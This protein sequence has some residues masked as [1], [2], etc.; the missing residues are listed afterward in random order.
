[1]LY[2]PQT[3][4]D[5]MSYCGPRW[6]T[7]YHYNRLMKITAPA[8]PASL[9]HVETAEEAAGLAYVHLSGEQP[10]L[11]V[12]GQMIEDDALTLRPFWINLLAPGQYD[13][14]GDGPYAIELLDGAGQ[15]LFVRRFDPFSGPQGGDH[16]AGAFHEILP[17]PAGVRRIVIRHGDLILAQVPVSAHAPTAR[18]LTPHADELWA[19]AGPFSVTWEMA[20]ADGDPL[21]TQVLYT[22]DGGETWLPVAVNLSGNAALLDGRALPGSEMARLR[23]RVSD[24]V[25][26]TAVESEPFRVAR[27][28]PLVLILLPQAEATYP[29]GVPIP[30]S[31]LGSDAEDGTLGDGALSWSSDRAG[32][33]GTG[34]SLFVDA[35]APGTHTITLT[36]RDSDGQ[37]SADSV[38][39]VV[40]LR[41]LVPLIRR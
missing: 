12:S 30:F 33:L 14:V 6:L 29:P 2:D 24:G 22:S 16:E 36:A 8:A 37:V 20:D 26:T 31:G 34:R 3:S 18:F 40:G 23:L 28:A 11:I 39:I 17:Y 38:R 9:T 41:V 32:G 13:Q 27:K 4:E 15:A 1:L 19:G 25:N 35:L 5:L 10:H 21:T 7:P